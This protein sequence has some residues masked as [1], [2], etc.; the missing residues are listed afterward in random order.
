M[1]AEAAFIQKV[2]QEAGPRRAGSQGESKGHDLLLTELSGFCDSI[3]KESFFAALTSK[4]IS[5]KIFVSLHWIGL[6][7]FWVNPVYALILSAVNAT[8]FF[9]HFISYRHVLDFLFPK[10]ESWN[11]E[12]VIEPL[13]EVKST[14]V[15]A[16]HMD[17]TAE[18]QWWYRFKNLG[19]KMTVGSG[20]L[21]M[22]LPVLYLLISVQSWLGLDWEMASIIG[23]GIFAVLSPITMVFFFLH[24]KIVVDGAIDNLSG[25][26]VALQTAKQLAENRLKHTRI[27]MVG[28]G[29]E[30][31]GL[32]GSTVFAHAHE[33]ALKKENAH[34]INIDTILSPEHL[35]IVKIEPS[36][37]V[38]YS[39]E[40][41]EKMG[42]TFS[43]Q[44]FPVQTAILPIGATDGVPF[45][46]L[47]IPAVSIVGIPVDS[48][49]PVYHTRE[50]NFSKVDEDCLADLTTAL[51]R[52]AREWD[53]Q[54]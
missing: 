14:L 9:L 16:G 48:L 47:K 39:P 35:H 25:I 37:Q 18:F 54:A 11:T 17:S 8:L 33:A 31:T 7:L 22:L 42:H 45:R 49:H 3:R 20:S 6:A 12:G 50:D 2:I 34:L 15:F 51:V 29:S 19:G 23:W 21:I 46:R 44:G 30:E 41:I 53:A 40:L 38:S 13:E 5:L 24:G 4:F 43:Q 1:K 26:A 27:R 10:I 32:R 36:A 28:F 52:F